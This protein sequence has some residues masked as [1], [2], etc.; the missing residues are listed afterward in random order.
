MG[1]PGSMYFMAYCADSLG[2]FLLHAEATV[3]DGEVVVS[4]EVVGVDGLQGLEGDDGVVDA[5]GLV[6]GDAEL[7]EGIAGL[8]VLGD[9]GLQ[10]G[11]GG[12][13]MALAALDD[14][15][16][17]EGAGAVGLEG[18]GAL[19]RGAGFAIFFPLDEVEAEVGEA[20][21]V[22]G[23]ELSD[24]LEGL[25]GVI[26]LK[27]VEVADAEV[28]PA[29]PVGVVGGE[30]RCDGVEAEVE[31]A[32][33]GGELDDRIRGVIGA[34]DVVEVGLAEVAV[35]DRGLDV[36]GAGEVGGQVELIA[37][38]G[39]AA[40]LD[41]VV[42]GD[43]VDGPDAVV[44]D[45]GALGV[46]G[47]VGEAVGAGVECAVGT[48]EAGLIEG[49]AGRV[50]D[51]EGDPGFVEIADFGD[52]RVA[53][54][55]ALDD[56]VGLEGVVGREGEGSRAERGDERVVVCGRGAAGFEADDIDVEVVAGL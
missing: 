36:D 3:E 50:G 41:G 33:A 49:V 9:D 12:F 14:G 24:V 5:V 15:E 26:V 52:E 27:L 10:V 11:D 4:G 53:D 21:G 17:V 38:E 29:H 43:G 40:G 34:E 56:D 55:F 22:V 2:G 25:H 18:Q 44:V 35:L 8:R 20:V 42:V 16:V 23:T 45:E 46:D 39:G 48:E 37:D 31:G 13:G 30:R 19:E 32:G 28:V 1:A 47:A 6:E 7:A 54:G 51:G